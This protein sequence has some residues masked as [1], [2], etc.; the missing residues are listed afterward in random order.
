MIVCC[1]RAIRAGLDIIDYELNGYII[2]RYGIKVEFCK[3]EPFAEEERKELIELV[4]ILEKLLKSEHATSGV[5]RNL[6]ANLNDHI[7]KHSLKLKVTD[8]Y[9]KYLLF[10]KHISIKEA[11]VF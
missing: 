11:M 8:K 4:F 2:E 5:T 10:F 7:I 3:E 1:E 6:L 9:H